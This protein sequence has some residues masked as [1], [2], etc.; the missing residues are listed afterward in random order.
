MWRGS[1][2]TG[3]RWDTVT[4]RLDAVFEDRPDYLGGAERHEP[5]GHVKMVCE[6]Y[7]GA[8][9]PVNTALAHDRA[10]TLAP[11]LTPMPPSPPTTASQYAET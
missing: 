9:V 3:G 11:L 6:E 8:L 2:P 7:Q 1:E 4:A 5:I 10:A